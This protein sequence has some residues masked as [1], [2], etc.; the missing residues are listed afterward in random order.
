M[1][2]KTEAASKLVKKPLLLETNA[3]TAHTMNGPTTSVTQQ[4]SKGNGEESFVK[5][6]LL[7]MEMMGK[8]RESFIFQWSRI[9]RAAYHLVKDH[10]HRIQLF[11][12]DSH[13]SIAHKKT[14]DYH[15][16]SVSQ[17]V[18]LDATQADGNFVTIGDDYFVCFWER[19][20][21]VH[22]VAVQFVTCVEKSSRG[23]LIAGCHNGSLVMVQQGSYKVSL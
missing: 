15:K 6:Q 11:T 4:G 17:I 7:I 23:L 1:F 16:A 18:Q 20:R 2:P 19:F 8:S 3:E 14:I 10:L 13:I 21:P 5:A 12:A 9:S 22:K